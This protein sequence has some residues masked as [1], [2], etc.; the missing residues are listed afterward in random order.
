MASI[1]KVENKYGTSYKIYVSDGL[2]GVK[3]KRHTTTYVPEPG[4]TERQAEKAARKAADAFEERVK[5]GSAMDMNIRFADFAQRWLD[6]YARMQLKPKTVA[7][8]EKR[9][10]RINQAIGNK[11]L[12]ELKTGH[13]NAFYANLQEP[14]MNVLSRKAMAKPLL[15]E[16][17]K[18][19]KL[20]MLKVS[21]DAGLSAST[22]YIACRGKM[23][24]RETAEKIA[25]ALGMKFLEC[26]TSKDGDGY[27][28]AETV[29]T[30]HRLLSSI[31][32]KAVKWGYI[33]IN[34]A[35]NAE[36]PK[37]KHQEADY[38][39][40]DDARRLLDLLRNE[41]IKY[42]TPI[43]FDLL[44][45]L[46]RGELLGLRWKDIDFENETVQVSETRTYIPGK[47]VIT[48]TPKNVSSKRP[49]RLSSSVFVLLRNYQ[50]W[51]EEQEI[52][53][54][55][56]WRNEDDYVFTNEDG[57]PLYP[58]TLSKWFRQF[59][60]RNGFQMKKIHGLRHSFASL[61]ISAGTPLVVV[62]KRLGHNQVSTTSNI[63]S[64]MIRSAEE[65]ALQAT[66]MF[67][68]QVARLK[69]V[70]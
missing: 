8:Y 16:T 65:K 41:P 48:D 39:D 33:S 6:E 47:G 57:S 51:Q 10:P 7:E 29:R 53:C 28:T 52:I 31:L 3:Q 44:S 30:Y 24:N 43:T 2:N 60:T 35:V 25:K 42:R 64:H 56:K 63:Y 21:K 70:K 15:K 1:Q 20:T 17:I 5:S 62:S 23:I 45:G 18:K 19:R 4:M 59:A 13:I 67:N 14:G 34:P 69:A 40:E 26:F 27:L 12:C 55:S 68:E 9:I 66:D 36:L 50:A 11:K 58:D 32:S 46:R 22:V 54:G 37:L 38:L 61:M 49:L